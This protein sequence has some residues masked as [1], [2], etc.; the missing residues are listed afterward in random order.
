MVLARLTVLAP[1][2][3]DIVVGYG[4]TRIDGPLNPDG[5]VDYVAA[6][7]ERCGKGITAQNNAALPLIQ[8]FG[9]EVFLGEA[10]RDKTLAILGAD[11]S[12][13]S[14]G[15]LVELD[16]FLVRR[17]LR[18]PPKKDWKERLMTLI[19]RPWSSREDPDFAAW[20]RT[21]QDALAL[22]TS[23]ADRPRFY[24]PLLPDSPPASLPD[25]RMPATVYLRKAARMLA[26]RAM[27]RMKSGDTDKAWADILTIHRLARRIGQGPSLISRLIGVVLDDLASDAGKTLA[28]A[29]N[30]SAA[31]ARAYLSAAEALGPLPGMAGPTDQLERMSLLDIAG[32][33]RRSGIRRLLGRWI[34]DVPA[35]IVGDLTLDWNEVLR[36][37]NSRCDRQVAA[38]RLPDW[39]ASREAYQRF[40]EDMENLSAKVTR[41]WSGKGLATILLRKA[42]GRPCQKSLSRSFAELLLSRFMPALGRA[43]ELHRRAA[44]KLEL[45]KLA[46]ALAAFKADQN[47]H[48]ATLEAMKGSYLKEIPQDIFSG[49]ALIYRRLDDGYLLYSVGLNGADD[50]GKPAKSLDDGD[51]VVRVE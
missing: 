35:R 48:P 46:L 39:A 32:R 20:L 16:A 12:A 2:D 36:V 24:M 9:A 30:L 45:V 5:T 29:G 43:H 49:K 23:A 17:G 26:A 50:G 19:Q 8:A 22:V 15:L 1:R 27:L 13:S 6:L 10:I 7:N 51:L 47:A 4:T 33:C 28:T 40:L 44:M 11:P 31:Q 37:I 34:G 3:V 21:N 42:V 18:Q 38:F 25:V 41:E 14:P